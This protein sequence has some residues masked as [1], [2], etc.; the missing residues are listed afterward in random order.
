MYLKC[1]VVFQDLLLFGIGITK[2]LYDIVADCYWFT[3]WHGCRGYSKWV[4]LSLPQ[5]T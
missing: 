2:M 3:I 1:Q 5:I 4:W